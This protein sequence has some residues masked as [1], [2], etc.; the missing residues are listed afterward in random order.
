M[1]WTYSCPHCQAILNPQDAIILMA[2]F[3]DQVWLVG[4]HPEPGKYEIYVP[5][6]VRVNSGDRWTFLC[7]VC[8]AD[9][10]TDFADTLCAIDIHTDEEDHRIF[11][12]RVAGDQATFVVSAE[13]LKSKYGKDAGSYDQETAQMKYLL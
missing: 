5:P 9:L 6:H 2:R 10:K 13:G 1:R 12:S 8:D 7:P 11:F 4:L 3:E